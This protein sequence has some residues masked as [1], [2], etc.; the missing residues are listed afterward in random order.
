MLLRCKVNSAVTRLS[1]NFVKLCGS[2]YHAV[3]P[4]KRW[5][6]RSEKARDPQS[7]QEGIP[8]IFW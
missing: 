3:S 6:V 7:N 5:Q 8:L 2:L 1:G 4:N